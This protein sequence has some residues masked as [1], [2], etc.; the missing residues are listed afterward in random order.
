MD[1]GSLQRIILA[2]G[3]DNQVRVRAY[4]KH[5]IVE[6]EEDGE[7]SPVARLTYLGNGQFGLGFHVH[8]G[9]REPMPFAGPLEMVADDMMQTLSPYLAKWSI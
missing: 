5:L 8:T 9:R 2:K 7:R 3:D 1:A 6:R 4:G